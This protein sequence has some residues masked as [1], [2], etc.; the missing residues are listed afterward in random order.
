MGNS[1]GRGI[2]PL[3]FL[4]IRG[5]LKLPF[6]ET[7]P[8]EE[9]SELRVMEHE[10]GGSGSGRFFASAN[11]RGHAGFIGATQAGQLAPSR[12]ARMERKSQ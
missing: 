4:L 8:F 5:W 12:K 6:R 11:D 7:F 2:Q 9:K 1:P 3:M 10:R